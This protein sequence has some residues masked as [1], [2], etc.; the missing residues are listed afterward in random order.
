MEN[1][2][3]DVYMIIDVNP[4]RIHI[5]TSGRNCT[6]FTTTKLSAAR[7]ELT[8]CKRYYPDYYEYKIIKITGFDEVK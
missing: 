4:E 3:E 1:K 7:R 5:H 6:P 2:I 8:N